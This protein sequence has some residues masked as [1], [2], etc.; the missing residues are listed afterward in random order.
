[1]SRQATGVEFVFMYAANNLNWRMMQ[2]G[3]R[4]IQ[5]QKKTVEI[6][7][8]PHVKWFFDG[9]YLMCNGKLYW[10]HLHWKLKHRPQTGQRSRYIFE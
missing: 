5:S 10:K 4:K 7:C 2:D 3:L 9:R 8:K 6:Q 1:M